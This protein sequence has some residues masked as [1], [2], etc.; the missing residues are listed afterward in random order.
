MQDAQIGIVITNPTLDDNPIVYVNRG[1]VSITQYT[2]EFAIGRNC[3]FLQGNATHKDDVRRIREAVEA[4]EEIEIRLIN[5]KADGSEFCNHLLITPVEDEHG[6]LTAF[7]AVQRAVDD[8]EGGTGGE[9]ERPDHETPPG[10]MLKELQHRVKNHLSMIVSLIR[11]QSRRELTKESFE[12]L[13]HRVE[14]L[15]MLYESML[16]A[17]D[18]DDGDQVNAGAYLSRVANVIGSI[19][20][21]PDIR[22][23]LDCD[24]VK[25]PVDVSGRLGLL[26]T[27]LLANTFE[28]AFKGRDKGLVEVQ[29][30]RIDDD[31]V[32]LVVE[33]DGT[34]LPEGSNWPE[35]SASIPE[36]RGRTED[37]EGELDTTSGENSSGLGG[38]IVR[39]LT[40]MLEA[41]IDVKSG[42][43]GTRISIDLNETEL[44]K[45]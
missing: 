7:F 23:K 18:D 16:S 38:S 39:G 13:A 14:A 45:L 41:D 5:H 2:R 28:H 29:F 10:I 34:G 30:C 25:L 37:E 15:A 17:N 9:S 19:S 4:G 26:L 35:E 8:C 31:V 1:F 36:Q 42:D 22:M 21:R 27:E 6:K 44:K 32:R 43:S 33:D 24:A 40:Q 20:G 12:A 3:R 11:L